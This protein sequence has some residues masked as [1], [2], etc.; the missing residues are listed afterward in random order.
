MEQT[1]RR[2]LTAGATTVTLGI[3]GCSDLTGGG[4]GGDEQDDESSSGWQYTDWIPATSE[5]STLEG[6]G[7][8]YTRPSDIA[9]NQDSLG[10]Y[11][12]NQR[13]DVTQLGI[14]YGDITKQA[15]VSGSFSNPLRVY[16]GTYSSDDV[17]GALEDTSTG[18][19][20]F[21]E[22]DTY[23][24]Y[25]L[26]LPVAPSGYGDETAEQEAV[27]DP[28]TAYGIS[29]STVVET[30]SARDMNARD[31][32]ELGVDTERGDATRYVDDDDAFSELTSEL[33]TT[34]S[35]NINMYE[36]AQQRDDPERFQFE[37][38]LGTGFALS[39]NGETSDYALAVV[40]ESEDGPSESALQTAYEELISGDFS[41][42]GDPT[43]TASGRVGTIEFTFPTEELGN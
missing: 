37:G 15:R 40:Y 39:F 26:Y 10:D 1:R 17:T 33:G 18:G 19:R 7:V 2:L 20:E 9:S 8:T 30:R 6:L 34:S 22:A 36:E 11:Y 23:E 42:E 29:G 16:E 14:D 25:T 35:M 5:L 31:V 27:E 24:G 3:A 13:R 43:F 12:E 21:V 41:P 32:L 28:E 4:G 38:A